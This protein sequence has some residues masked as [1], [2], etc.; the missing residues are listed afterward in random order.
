MGFYRR[1]KKKKK[2]AL[3]K[4]SSLIVK[5]TM[6]LKVYKFLD[7]HATDML[8][9]MEKKDLT[10]KVPYDVFRLHVIER[11]FDKFINEE[12]IK[13]LYHIGI[14]E[15]E[16]NPMADNV[17]EFTISDEYKSKFDIVKNIEPDG[18]VH[19]N[20]MHG[21]HDAILTML[22]LSEFGPMSTIRLEPHE[23]H[24]RQ[25]GSISDPFDDEIFK[26]YP[27]LYDEDGKLNLI[28]VLSKANKHMFKTIPIPAPFKDSDLSIEDFAAILV[29]KSIHTGEQIMLNEKNQDV[30][31]PVVESPSTNVY[32]PDKMDKSLENKLRMEGTL[33]DHGNVSGCY[34]DLNELYENK[35]DTIE[36]VP[37]PIEPLSVKVYDGSDKVNAS[38]N[39]EGNN[40]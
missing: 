23:D 6:P 3:K 27:E 35:K 4:R 17:I 26:A 25:A 24:M 29:K 7:T 32:T 33:E 20:K 2:N 5:E 21:C 9:S 15:P 18:L 34:A 8:N 37:N 10:N 14:C 11:I 30:Q 40:D 31:E 1:E 19:L 38:A 13:D 39:D 12:L 36:T 28:K 16:Y 22:G